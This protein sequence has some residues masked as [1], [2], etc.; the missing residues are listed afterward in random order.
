MASSIPS[1]WRVPTRQGT[2]LPQD[3]FWVKVIKK[4]AMST[5][6][7]SSS[8]VTIPPEPTMDPAWARV[9]YSTGRSM[10]WAGRQPPEGPPDWTAL[11]WRFPITPP[12]DIVDDVVEGGAQG[13]LYQ[14]AVGDFAGEGEDQGAPALLCPDGAVPV[15]AAVDDEGDTGQGLYIVDVGGPAPQAFLCGGGGG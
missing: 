3:S 14:A 13:H 7:V 10:R 9:S 5:M 8:M 15:G 6:Q 11:I 12:D 1:I 2:H 4:R